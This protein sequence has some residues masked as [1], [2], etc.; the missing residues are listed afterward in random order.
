MDNPRVVQGKLE[1]LETM[2]AKV[3]WFRGLSFEERYAHLQSFLDFI[4]EVNPK[5]ARSHAH[6]PSAT[7]RVLRRP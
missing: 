6:K 7:A 4:A 2:E 1:D 5:L 3:A